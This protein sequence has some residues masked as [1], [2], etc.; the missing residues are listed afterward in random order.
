MSERRYGTRFLLRESLLRA[1]QMVLGSPVF[2]LPGVLSLRAWALRRFFPIGPGT[3]IADRVSIES[4]HGVRGSFRCGARVEI[5]HGAIL[6]VTGGLELEDDVWV[7]ERALIFTHDHR[8]T[9]GAPKS[10]WPVERSAKVIAA[11]AWIGANAIV[12]PQA[13][14][15]GRRA[16]VAAGSVVTRDVPDHAVVAGSPAR[17][18]GS[19]AGEGAG[20]PADSRSASAVPARR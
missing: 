10:A 4:H 6:D 19:T 17:V 20:S 16:V 8:V 18:V 1:V 14:R 3:R 12:L 11:D 5:A 7:S 2:N 13:T 9:R 15:I